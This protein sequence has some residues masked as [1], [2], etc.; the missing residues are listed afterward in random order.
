[1]PKSVD[2][3]VSYK[4]V[5]NNADSWPSTSVDSQLQ[6]ENT[7]LDLQLVESSDAKLGDTED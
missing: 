6:T 5:W 2:A 7:V 3:Q 1:M 4:T